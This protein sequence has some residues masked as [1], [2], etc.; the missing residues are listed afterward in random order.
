[1][2][3]NMRTMI[4]ACVMAAAT[5]IPA[6]ATAHVATGDSAATED[7]SVTAAGWQR[8]GPFSSKAECERVRNHLASLG[9]ATQPCRFLI[10]DTA[11]CV[12]GWYYY[13]WK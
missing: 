2:Q 3:R 5:L 1:M 13:I 8:R 12:S 6:G 11:P 4:G 9:Y 10:C 7:S